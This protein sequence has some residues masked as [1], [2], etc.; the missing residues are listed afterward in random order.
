M[1]TPASRILFLFGLLLLVL[2]LFCGK[3]KTKLNF[4]TFKVLS[5]G[6]LNTCTMFCGPHHY[7]WDPC[8]SVSYPMDLPILDIVCKWNHSIVWDLS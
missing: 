6:A 2:L 7:P 8:L 1:A 4:F 3:I 5:S